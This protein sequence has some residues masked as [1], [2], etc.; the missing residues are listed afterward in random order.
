[1]Q[2]LDWFE[3]NGIEKKGSVILYKKVSKDFKTQEGTENET[4]WKIGTTLNHP[5]W[6]P[7][8]REC[9][10]GKYHACSKPYF[11]DDFRNGTDDKYIAIK[12]NS[13]DL[14]EWKKPEYPHKIAFRKGKILF[15]CDKEGSA[16]KVLEGEKN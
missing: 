4:R 16:I 1:M 3:T 11:C 13:K 14:Y 8:E 5:K 10:E 15:E 6:N 7:E 2:A 9:G 12:I